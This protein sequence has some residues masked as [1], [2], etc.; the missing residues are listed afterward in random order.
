MSWFPPP[1]SGVPVP[2]TINAVAESVTAAVNVV[3]TASSAVP[4]IAAMTMTT[5]FTIPRMATPSL[6]GFG[7]SLRRILSSPTNPTEQISKNVAR[8]SSNAFLPDLEHV[9][10]LD[11]HDSLRQIGLQY[12]E[13][14][15]LVWPSRGRAS[16]VDE[17]SGDEPGLQQQCDG[18]VADAHLEYEVLEQSPAVGPQQRPVDDV[19]V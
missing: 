7:K 4:R 5:V 8:E 3:V 17:L 9:D 13:P 10:R 14:L 18:P 16:E 12:G 1:G 11:R 6:L 2:G 15:I 19:A